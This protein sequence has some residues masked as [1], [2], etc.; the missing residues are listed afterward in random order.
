MSR[1]RRHRRVVSEPTRLDASGVELTHVLPALPTGD[2]ADR[3]D[4]VDP[5]PADEA[6]GPAAGK[7]APEQTRDDTDE[8]W[9]ERPRHDEADEA[10]WRAQR[11]PHW[12]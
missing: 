2:G 9:G 10:W 11:P 12:S 5:A 7:A 1:A 8:G 6:R 4:E 3:A